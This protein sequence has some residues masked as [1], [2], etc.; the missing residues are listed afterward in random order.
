MAEHHSAY[1]VIEMSDGGFVVAGNRWL[2]SENSY[3]VYL[4]R[5]DSNG[6][7]L[8]TRTYGGDKNDG[9]I[10]AQQTS[11]G[12]FIM[13]GATASFGSF[14]VSLYAIR[15]DSLGDTL[16]T[17]IYGGWN[18]LEGSDQANSVQQVSDGGFIIFGDHNRDLILIRTDSQGDTLWTK[19]FGGTS[20]DHGYSV[21]LT[22]DSGF[23]IACSSGPW[24]LVK[25]NSQGDILWS[26]PYRSIQCRDVKQTNDGGFIVIGT[27]YNDTSSIDIYLIRTD[28]KGDTL[29]IKS[30]GGQKTDICNSIQI[31]K[32]GGFIIIGSTQSFSDIRTD[33]YLIR[34]DFKGDTLWTKLVSRKDKNEAF[35]IKQTRNGGFIVCGTS[36]TWQNMDWDIYLIRLDKETTEIKKPFNG[37]QLT[38]N[39]LKNIK[40]IEIYDLLGR[41]IKTLPAGA[42]VGKWKKGNG[43]YVVRFVGR[44]VVRRKVLFTK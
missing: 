38:V 7:T 16:W 8:W 5:I 20:I 4:M 25:L 44:D 34:T 31:T 23:V 17:R 12:G 30:F 13:V 3:D 32:D 42:D 6:D 29:W 26:K 1:S 37:Q 27:D 14:P 24:G 2:T 19:T 28:E 11:D 33:V 43:V 36:L 15:T 10:S 39:S 35:S 18:G 9:C 22:N 41:K 40:R 21:Q